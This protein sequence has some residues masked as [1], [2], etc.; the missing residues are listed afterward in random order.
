M[1][2]KKQDRVKSGNVCR[3]REGV[4]REARIALGKSATGLMPDEA[5]DYLHK[6]VAKILEVLEKHP[7][8]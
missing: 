6:A 4:L 8:T 7:F 3:D 1:D 5:V 2:T